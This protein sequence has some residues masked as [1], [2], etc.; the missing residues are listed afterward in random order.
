MTSEETKMTANW[1]DLNIA[2]L[3]ASQNQDSTIAK[4][5]IDLRRVMPGH[6]IF[7]YDHSDG[8][9]TA[10]QAALAGAIV[11]TTKRS[12]RAAVVRQML[13]E[14]EADIYVLVDGNGRFDPSA[15]PHI[16]QALIDDRADM[17]VASEIAADTS[18]KPV[19]KSK[20]DQFNNKILG[21]DCIDI[22]SRFRA[23]T[24]RFAKS[25][26]TQN[27]RY[28]AETDMSVYAC[29]LGLNVSEI[30]YVSKDETEKPRGIGNLNKR[31]S[32]TKL[33]L[34]ETRPFTLFGSLTAVFIVSSLFFMLPLFIQVFV[35]GT[36]GGLPS[37][38]LA[39]S[40]LIC[41]ALS[42]CT[43]VVTE[44]LARTRI[45]Q[46]RMHY[47]S[48]ALTRGERM[49]MGIDSVYDRRNPDGA[50]SGSPSQRARNS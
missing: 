6:R 42:L 16:V 38:V 3:F 22:D 20:L 29:V 15:I 26:I 50:W 32:M 9:E 45:E 28:S 19:C 30:R 23:M 40:L 35:S 7:V 39:T 37:W 43:G 41:A 5:L 33:L 14:I 49:N 48:L 25:F 12:G 24:R 36:V 4:D 44:L 34:K 1:R 8:P 21:T 31:L 13:T 47:Q 10:Q 27:D 11:V 2:L 17:V 46:T 18:G